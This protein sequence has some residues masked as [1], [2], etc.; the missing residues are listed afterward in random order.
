MAMTTRE[1]IQH[2]LLNC[3]LDDPVNIEVRIPNNCTRRLLCFEP[4]HAFRVGDDS[5]CPETLVE[6]KPWKET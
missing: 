4:A 1:F 6:C 3:E 2:L 5:E